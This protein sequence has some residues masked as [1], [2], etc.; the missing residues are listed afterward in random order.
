LLRRELLQPEWM[1]PC[2]GAYLART[3]AD[4]LLPDGSDALSQALY[5]EATS[6]LSGDMLV[7]VD[8]MS[9]AASLEVRSPLLDHELADIAAGVPHAWKIRN[10]QGKY[11]LIRALGDRLPP[12]IMNR[13]KM[14]F[15]IPL[16]G[17]L[18][19]PLRDMLRDHLDSPRFLER[20]IVSPPFVRHM[21]DE[22]QTGR[23]D[24][25][26]WLW[27]LLVL[28]MWFRDHER[29]SAPC[30]LETAMA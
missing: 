14:G 2:D 17:W 21:L 13:P 5:F 6:K 28:E 23:R 9:M 18:R 3:F 24:N 8:R 12:E 29:R 16:A 10:G 7:K 26:S 22:H 30:P 19:G 15:A 11:I 27:A 25:R 1:L 20:G 4:C